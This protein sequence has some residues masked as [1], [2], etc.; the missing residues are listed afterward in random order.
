MEEILHSLACKRL[1]NT[2]CSK[3]YHC[4]IIFTKHRGFMSPLSY[5]ENQIRGKTSIHAEE[6][7]INKIPYKKDG[8][9]KKVSLL[10]LRVNKL[11][12]LTM[13]KPCKHCIQKMNEIIHKNYK[14]TSVYFTNNE[15]DI[16]KCSLNQLNAEP[17]K[18]ISKFYR[19]N[20]SF[21]RL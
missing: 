20:F 9:I 18:H 19:E 11:G 1:S 21:S 15:G 7:C 10:V 12:N 3:F 2:K 6:D 16:E 14:I 4:S 17:D 8:K 5:G 13:S